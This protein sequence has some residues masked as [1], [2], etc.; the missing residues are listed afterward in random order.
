[1]TEHLVGIVQ[2]VVFMYMHY[3]TTF[4]MDTCFSLLAMFT[5]FYII[6]HCS[7]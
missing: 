2:Y 7:I 5:D 6:L 3:G 4:I 1:M